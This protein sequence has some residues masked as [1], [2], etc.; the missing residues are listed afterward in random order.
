MHVYRG[1]ESSKTKKDEE[2]QKLKTYIIR[3]WLHINDKVEPGVEKYWPIRHEL[4][5]VDGFAVKDK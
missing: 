3:V 1:Q 2:L 4:A 5:M